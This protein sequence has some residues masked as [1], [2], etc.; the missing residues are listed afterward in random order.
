MLPTRVF[1][2]C[3]GSLA[4]LDIASAATD[5]SK[6]IA[7]CLQAQGETD[8]GPLSCRG[9]ISGQCMD[10]PEGQSTVGMVECLSTETQAWDVILNEEYSRLLA[11][12]KPDPAEVVKKAQRLW[13][14][15][16]DADCAVPYNF[17]DGGTIV[18]T[19]GAECF[20]NHTADRATLIKSWRE[21]AQGE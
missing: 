3:A 20:L 6:S 7:A 17:Y 9:R 13:V 12:L 21:M 4:F 2:V 5:E 1:I 18:Q 10:K 8:K 15:G 16:R 14:Q 11:L 19:R